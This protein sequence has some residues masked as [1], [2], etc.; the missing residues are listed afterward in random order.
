MKKMKSERDKYGESG[1]ASGAGSG[2]PAYRGPASASDAVG[3][4][5][6]RGEGRLDSQPSLLWHGP[7]NGHRL[8]YYAP[9][10]EHIEQS[11]FINPT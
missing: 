3:R 11:R 2:D 8:H 7:A 9:D 1:D 10:A 4:V 5:P 6:S